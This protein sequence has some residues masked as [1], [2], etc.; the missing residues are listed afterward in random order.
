MSAP[1]AH[2]TTAIAKQPQELKKITGRTT[3]KF[4]DDNA[5]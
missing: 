4:L 1:F 2:Q 5:F 3:G